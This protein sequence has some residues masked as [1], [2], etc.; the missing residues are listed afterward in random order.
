MNALANKLESIDD[1]LVKYQM[2]QVEDFFFLVHFKWK[3]KNLFFTPWV[4]A[5]N[6]ATLTKFR[7]ANNAT[8]EK[9]NRIKLTNLLRNLAQHI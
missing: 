9:S 8:R 5:L 7:P 4:L 2:K 1:I 6:L 3:G